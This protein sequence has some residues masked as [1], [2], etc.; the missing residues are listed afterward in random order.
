M[1]YRPTEG[2]GCGQHLCPAPNLVQME[3][4]SNFENLWVACYWRHTLL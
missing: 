2:V 3:C 4:Q 1:N